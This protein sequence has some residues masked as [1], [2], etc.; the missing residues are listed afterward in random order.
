MK[1][2]KVQQNQDYEMSL[3]FMSENTTLRITPFN[4]PSPQTHIKDIITK[5]RETWEEQHLSHFINLSRHVKTRLTGIFWSSMLG[6]GCQHVTVNFK[7]LRTS[8]A[9][10]SMCS[11][12]AIPNRMFSGCG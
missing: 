1:L 2:L 8:P 9:V 11:D 7:S 3:R 4:N 12:M 10:L 6:S 5:K